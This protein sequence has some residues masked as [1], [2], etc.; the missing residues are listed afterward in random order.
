M[1]RRVDPTGYLRLQYT[2]GAARMNAA[3][4]DPPPTNPLGTGEYTPLAELPAGPRYTRSSLH[5][6][7]GMGEVWRAWTSPSGGRWRSSS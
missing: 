3:P 7:G 2:G 6:T 1:L 5:A 4:P